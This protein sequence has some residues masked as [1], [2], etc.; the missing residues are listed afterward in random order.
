MSGIEGESSACSSSA[1][2]SITA[3]VS[4]DVAA[5][6]AFETFLR[7]YHGGGDA[8]RRGYWMT[9]ALET[10]LENVEVASKETWS[11]H[12]GSRGD[13]LSEACMVWLHPLLHFV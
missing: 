11:V 7:P 1:H 6:R 8:G 3:V 9:L 10:V 2:L 4:A 12:Y 13:C 5:F